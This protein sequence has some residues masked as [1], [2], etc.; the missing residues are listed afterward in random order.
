V[1]ERTW[2]KVSGTLFGLV[3]VPSILLKIRKLWLFEGTGRIR[4]FELTGRY[5]LFFAVADKS[6]EVRLLEN[7][8][9]LLVEVSSVH[10]LEI[11][12]K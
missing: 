7:K 1:L 9:S 5:H 2:L 6:L 12:F 4:I 3:L 11:R 10:K 8:E